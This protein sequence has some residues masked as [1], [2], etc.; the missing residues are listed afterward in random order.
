MQ[1]LAIL[2]ENLTPDKVLKAYHLTK[3]CINVT[4]PTASANCKSHII[5]QNLQALLFQNI[6][7]QDH[8]FFY[9]FM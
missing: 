3:V 4:T 2:L 5:L 8:N 1:H 6:L 7:Q 9:I